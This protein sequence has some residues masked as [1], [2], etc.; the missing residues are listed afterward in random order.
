MAAKA[1]RYSQ[2]TQFSPFTIEC[3]EA[4]VLLGF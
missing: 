2:G 4:L 1:A 3:L